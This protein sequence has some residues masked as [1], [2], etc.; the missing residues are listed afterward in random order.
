MPPETDWPSDNTT[1]IED[2]YATPPNLYPKAK[3]FVDT[4]IFEHD[5]IRGGVEDIWDALQYSPVCISVD[6]NATDENV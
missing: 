5:T 3:P 1:S 4:Y 2:F 6:L